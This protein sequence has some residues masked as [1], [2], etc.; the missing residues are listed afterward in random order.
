M[1]S[2]SLQVSIVPR[3]GPQGRFSVWPVQATS[4]MD[5]ATSLSTVLRRL[6]VLPSSDQSLS[7][8]RARTFWAH[9]SSRHG[10]GAGLHPARLRQRSS[11]GSMSLATTIK[12]S[13]TIRRGPKTACGIRC[14]LKDRRIPDLPIGALIIQWLQSPVIPRPSAPNRGISVVYLADQNFDRLPTH[15]EGY[16]CPNIQIDP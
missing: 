10:H 3:F 13:R 14:D 1:G 16:L 6:T 2:L 8:L 7:A 11:S 9:L 5:M 4:Q 15:V 12:L